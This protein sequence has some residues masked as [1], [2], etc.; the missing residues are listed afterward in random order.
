MTFRVTKSQ[1]KSIE[2][3][4]AQARAE[5][6]RGTSKMSKVK[7][8][9]LMPATSRGQQDD[10]SR[11]VPKLR[12]DPTGLLEHVPTMPLP[13][14]FRLLKTRMPPCPKLGVQLGA[15]HLVC[16]HG[17][18]RCIRR[19]SRHYAYIFEKRDIL[20]RIYIRAY[21]QE[22]GD[23]MKKHLIYRFLRTCSRRQ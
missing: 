23:K 2:L 15:C 19:P 16:C 9:N 17:E 4:P 20:W 11:R 22:K 10:L 13:F 1:D 6:L 5:S 7:G 12:E 3:R 8:P 18:E 21:I 14:A